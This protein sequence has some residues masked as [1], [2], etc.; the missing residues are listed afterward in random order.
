MKRWHGSAELL[1]RSCRNSVKRADKLR[2]D[3]ANIKQQLI[4]QLAHYI[5]ERLHDGGWS[6]SLAPPSPPPRNEKEDT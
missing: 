4:E 1:Y 3:M 2:S 6:S 5:P